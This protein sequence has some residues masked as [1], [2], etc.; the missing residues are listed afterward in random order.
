[1]RLFAEIV[2]VLICVLIGPDVLARTRKP[3]E[4]IVRNI[5]RSSALDRYSYAI[6]HEDSARTSTTGA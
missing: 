1:M 2:N 5:R 3:E 6:L 4:G